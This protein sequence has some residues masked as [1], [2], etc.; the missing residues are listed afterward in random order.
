MNQD[1]RK[2]REVEMQMR[3]QTGMAAEI[4]KDTPLVECKTRICDCTERLRL[5]KTQI[6]ATSSRLL[7]PQTEVPE[8]KVESPTSSG[9]LPELQDSISLLIIAV[10][11][12]ESE[13]SELSGAI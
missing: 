12:L 5:M 13:I 1:E 9:E 8:G 10:V 6:D 7:G 11:R 2:Q 4:Q 3:N